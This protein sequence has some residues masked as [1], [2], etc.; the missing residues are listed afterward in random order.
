MR[1][2]WVQGKISAMLAHSPVSLC[3]GDHQTQAAGS[4]VSEART[5]LFLHSRHLLKQKNH[6][7][8]WGGC[9]GV[10]KETANRFKGHPIT[11]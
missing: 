4:Q 7:A 3:P 8:G 10:E 6:R 11:L 9:R 5:H 1:M 2:N